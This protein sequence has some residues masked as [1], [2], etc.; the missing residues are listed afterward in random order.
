V[1]EAAADRAAAMRIEA[2]DLSRASVRELIAEHL[3]DMHAT[4]PPESVHALDLTGLREPGVSFWTA[5]AGERLLGCGALKELSPRAGELKAMRTAGTARGQGVGAA[6]LGHLL[7]EARRR[8]YERVNLETGP[9]P[10][11]AAARRLYAR[12][13]F[14]ECGPFADYVDDPY[15]VFMTRPL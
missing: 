15:S 2:D 10:Y 1:R 4:S 13:G 14:V 7:D 11:F 12:H 5:W 3:T 9:Q 6:M 8:G